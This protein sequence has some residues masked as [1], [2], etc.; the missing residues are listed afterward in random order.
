MPIFD[1]FSKRRKR[2]RGEMPD[3]YSYDTLTET[4]RVQIIHIVLGAMG[5]QQ[6]YFV[7]YQFS[8]FD[9]SVVSA[10]QLVVDTLCREYGVFQLT[11]THGHGDRI[12][13]KE[14]LDFFLRETNIEKSLDVV[15]LCF[16][17]ID[18][19]TRDWNY[20]HRQNASVVADNAIRELNQRFQEHGVGYRF[21]Y[22][23]IVRVDSQL[24]HSEVVKP[25]LTLLGQR[26]YAGA[27]QEF[28][29]AHEHY[30][31][32]KAK[33]ALNECL[34]AFES[35]MKTICYRRGWT[36]AD[37]AT[38]KVLIKVCF[39]NEI[40]PPF[41][42]SHF[43]ALRN[44]LESGIPTGRN[45]LSGHGQGAAPTTV[46]IH[47]VGYVLHMTAAAIVF[48]AEADADMGRR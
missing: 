35:V 9:R 1:L 24:I 5:N 16:R 45:K 32:G 34:K 26:Q 44:L 14:L 47:I 43:S 41:W 15:E 40:I 8:E 36:Y 37:G 4:L 33:E 22:G 18:Q 10:Y 48:L 28:L 6:E 38:A 19:D 27:Q 11:E 3:V 21:E 2:L 42:Q 31:A 25:A 20:L 39:D 29:Q 13:P 46:P 17:A 23:Q 7:D 30:R 12:Y